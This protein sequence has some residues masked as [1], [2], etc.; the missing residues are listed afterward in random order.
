[1]N[2]RNFDDLAD[3]FE[4]RVHHSAK[5]NLRRSIIWR[6]IEKQFTQGT[7]AGHCK[8]QKKLDIIDIGAGLGYFAIKLADL[9]HCVTYNDLSVAMMQ[10]AQEFAAKKNIDNRITWSNQPYQQLLEKCSQPVDVILCH[11]LLEWL[12]QPSH[13]IS[14]IKKALKPKGLLSLCFYNPAGLIYRNLICGNFRYLET[15]QT[16]SNPE[17]T[18]DKLLSITADD[19]S[20][21]P[22]NPSS[23][24][25]VKQWLADSGFTIEQF[26]G[27]R[28]FSDYVLEKRGGHQSPDA[29]MAMEMRYSQLEPY[30]RIGRYIHIIATASDTKK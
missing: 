6:D 3:R 24:E 9:G 11:A 29:I 12:E 13:A 4:K 27:I 19:N 18:E 25:Q 26:T 17:S 16:N 10:K 22:T 30:K 21:T 20:L 2:D 8:E 1:M 7:L 14:L 15:I 23:I 28:V 5:G